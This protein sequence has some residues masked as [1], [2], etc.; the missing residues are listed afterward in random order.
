MRK[1]LPLVELMDQVDGVLI[2]KSKGV[3]F[4]ELNHVRLVVL[5]SQGCEIIQDLL[6]LVMRVDFDLNFLEN[7][8]I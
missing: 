6:L 5:C 7:M 2:V 3:Q 4:L 8:Q 1:Q